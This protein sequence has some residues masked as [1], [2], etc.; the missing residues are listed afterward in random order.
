MKLLDKI[1]YNYRL[2]NFINVFVPRNRFSKYSHLGYYYPSVPKA[3]DNI[4][5][6]FLID[7]EDKIWPQ[8]YLPRFIKRL[9]HYF[10]FN[11]TC[12]FIYNYWFYNLRTKLTKGIIITDI[13]D[14]YADIR[15]YG[16]F[17]DEIYDL[18]EKVENECSETCEN[19]GEKN[20]PEI[21]PI[22]GWYRNIC[23]NCLVK[24]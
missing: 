9:I 14:K 20:N 24:K 21:I 12:N 8:R 17:S 6:Q 4:V 22:N 16:H 11:N 10:A 7:V 2:K 15:I 23:K 1:K 5:H 19:C 3:W 13:K 18:I